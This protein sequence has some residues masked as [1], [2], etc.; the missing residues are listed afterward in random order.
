MQVSCEPDFDTAK[1]TNAINIL[2][3]K[4]YVAHPKQ[5]SLPEIGGLGFVTSWYKI[6]GDNSKMILN[7]TNETDQNAVFINVYSTKMDVTV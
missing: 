4:T 1:C 5:N 7:F 6:E 2:C 3:N